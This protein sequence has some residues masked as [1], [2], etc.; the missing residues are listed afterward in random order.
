MLCLKLRIAIVVKEIW[1][2][3]AAFVAFV[4]RFQKFLWNQ[5]Q[6]TNYQRRD[7]EYEQRFLTDLLINGLTQKCQANAL[8]TEMSHVNGWQHT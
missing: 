8:H 4:Y 5:N 1:N 3:S 6:I 7:V 2:M